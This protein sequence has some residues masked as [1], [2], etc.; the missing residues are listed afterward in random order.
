MVFCWFRRKPAGAI[1]RGPRPGLVAGVLLQ[2]GARG[3]I[4]GEAQEFQAPRT[5]KMELSGFPLW[6]KPEKQKQASGRKKGALCCL[7]RC[8]FF[9]GGLLGPNRKKALM[10]FQGAS[11]RFAP[12]GRLVFFLGIGPPKHCG[13]PFGIP[14]KPSKKDTQIRVAP[15]WWFLFCFPFNPTQKG[16]RFLNKQTHQ[17]CRV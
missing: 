4:R 6:A 5:R 11:N 10:P 7:S 12:D 9:G 3:A 16:K 1:L 13:N 2:Q 14:S 8:F 17:D 15:K